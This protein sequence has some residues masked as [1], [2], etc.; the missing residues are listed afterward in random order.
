M[1]VAVIMS[2]IIGCSSVP[3]YGSFLRGRHRAQVALATDSVSKLRR[4][5]APERVRVVY[6]QGQA[7]PFG[8][9]LAAGLRQEGYKVRSGLGGPKAFT[10]RYVVDRVK[11]TPLLR[12]TLFVRGRVLSRAYKEHVDGTVAV[13]PWSS[14]GFHGR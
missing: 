7:D 14:G 2:L 8:R 6:T 13:G 10:V 11:N 4:D 3:Q 1:R 5:Y 9:G 12:V